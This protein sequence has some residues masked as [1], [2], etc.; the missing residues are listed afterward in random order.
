MGDLME[1]IICHE[2]GHTLGLRHNFASSWTYDA[3]DIR[4]K[5]F[6]RRESHG[7]SVMDYMR[8][9]YVAQPGGGFTTTDVIPRLGDYDFYAIEWG[10][11]Y[12]PQFI[13][14]PMEE[15]QYL[16][17]WATRQRKNNHRLKFGIETDRWDPRF[18]AE[19]LTS[20]AIAAN[21]LGMQNLVYCR[22]HPR[23]V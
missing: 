20:D 10:Y 7:A 22:Q 19:D 1:Y 9:N 4:N 11:R 6:V 8:F 12:L 23:M 18:Q 2:I 21:E 17:K 15:K 14:K 13:G 16:M 5:D 3:Q